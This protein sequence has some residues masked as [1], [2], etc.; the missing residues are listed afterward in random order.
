MIFFFNLKDGSS[1]WVQKLTTVNKES[2]GLMRLAG[3]LC[4]ERCQQ[5]LEGDSSFVRELYN[6]GNSSVVN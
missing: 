1:S 3:H 6:L 4:G 2:G 5:V